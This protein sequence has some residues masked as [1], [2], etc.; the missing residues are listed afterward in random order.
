VV[1]NDVS[2]TDRYIKV[3]NSIGE[4]MIA[5]SANVGNRSQLDMSNFAKGTYLI[6]IITEQG[7]LT[8]KLLLITE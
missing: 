6:Q 4:L 8:K 3:Y 7:E 5:Q 2:L 1:W